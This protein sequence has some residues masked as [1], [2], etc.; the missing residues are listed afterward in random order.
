MPS[1]LEITNLKGHRFSGGE[2]TVEHWENFLLTACTGG[3]LMQHGV[4]H[5]VVLFHMPILGSGTS[6]TEMGALGQA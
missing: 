3:D 6:I 4:V 5:P 2:Y 1:E